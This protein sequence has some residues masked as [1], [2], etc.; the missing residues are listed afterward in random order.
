MSAPASAVV[1]PVKRFD[2]AKHRLSDVLTPDERR[3]L[4][5]A[6]LADVLAALGRVE[7]PY[8]LMVVTSEPRASRA[9]AALGA[10]VVFDGGQPGHS[11]A[12][13]LGT[14]LCARRG[15]ER[16]LLVPADC[17]LLDATAVERLLS[18]PRDPH[19]RVALV[20]D[21]AG[22]GTN[23]LLLEPPEAIQPAFG[24]GSR[25]RHGEAAAARG[26]PFQALE[27]PSLQLDVDTPT[28]LA[29]LRA[30]LHARPHAAPHTAAALRGLAP[31]QGIR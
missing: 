6:M 8:A 24:P 10:E 2:R 5:E 22:E 20:T 30:A 26:I 31:V 28:D 19:G 11:E 27:I 25:R 29:A 4:M 3:A 18:P 12:A 15:V 21:R 9:A 1:L 13:A 16:A 17:P 14:R 7:V 23:A